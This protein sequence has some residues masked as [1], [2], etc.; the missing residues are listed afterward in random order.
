[1]IVWLEAKVFVVTAVAFATVGM[2][3]KR[4]STLP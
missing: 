1:M 2:K 4:E 3:G